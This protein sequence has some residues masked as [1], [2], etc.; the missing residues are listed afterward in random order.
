M[1]EKKFCW[2]VFHNFFWRSIKDV[3]DFFII[4]LLAG[5]E[6]GKLNFRQFPKF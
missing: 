4:L 5:N 1:M 3:R 2:R 6:L